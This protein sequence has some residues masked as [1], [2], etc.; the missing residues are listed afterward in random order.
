MPHGASIRIVP[1]AVRSIVVS[2]GYLYPAIES[3]KL[4]GNNAVAA[5][6]RKITKRFRIAVL[7]LHAELLRVAL[8]F[9]LSL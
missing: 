7:Y 2:A 6:A 3:Q 1:T 8:H 9:N 5:E 4:R